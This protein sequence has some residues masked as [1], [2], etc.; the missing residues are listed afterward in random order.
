MSNEEIIIGNRLIAFSPFSSDDV[1][2]WVNDIGNPSD[3]FLINL[4]FHSSW[5]ALMPIRRK[6][7]ELFETRHTL[8]VFEINSHYVEFYLDGFKWIAGCYSESPEKIKLSSELEALWYVIVEFIKWYNENK[9][10]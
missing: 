6:I 9:K 5:D 2:N 3:K 10:E 8:P 7:I 1:R 4:K